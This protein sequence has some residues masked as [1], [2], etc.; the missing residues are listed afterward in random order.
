MDLSDIKKRL[1]EHQ[2]LVRDVEQQRELRKQR[3]IK[4]DDLK[5]MSAED[6]YQ[7]LLNAMSD[8]D[9]SNESDIEKKRTIEDLLQEKKSISDEDL[10]KSEF[11]VIKDMLLSM[12]EINLS[13]RKDYIAQALARETPP[14]PIKK[15]LQVPIVQSGPT[16]THA[17]L[18]N[19]MILDPKLQL[20]LGKP[21]FANMER[22]MKEV[23]A[24]PNY[25]PKTAPVQLVED[26][27]PDGT[28]VDSKKTFGGMKME[29]VNKFYLRPENL[30]LDE[31]TNEYVNEPPSLL[32][33]GQ[34]I[35]AYKMQKE[36]DPFTAAL[37]TLMEQAAW[38]RQGIMV[39]LFE[40]KINENEREAHSV[41]FIYR[42]GELKIPETNE[43]S[44]ES[45]IHMIAG[46][47]KFDR[48]VG[49]V[50]ATEFHGLA[51]DHDAEVINPK[52]EI[53][54]EIKRKVRDYKSVKGFIEPVPFN[55]STE[56][57]SDEPQPPA[58]ADD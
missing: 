55:L 44:K 27:K 50:V 18:L 23:L 49:K 54:E 10:A 31:E 51:Y 24:N 12:D 6:R 25:D 36:K 35:Y 8:L 28:L 43:F 15:P 48:E 58:R 52:L 17:S 30:V 53:P 22:Y 16:C 57:E 5:A 47:E 14:R 33:S 45:I 11:E 38:Y 2:A 46:N 42:D 1:E 13:P 19:L 40:K 9:L 56:T 7:L 34:W 20:A 26:V 39:F 32:F 41:P 3:R 29:D 37:K 4:E 21:G